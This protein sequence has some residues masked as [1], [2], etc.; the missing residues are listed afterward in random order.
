M[1]VPW[2][3]LYARRRD[4]Q[5]R[6]GRIHALPVTKRARRVIAPQVRPGMRVLDVGA[7]ARRVAEVLARD[8]GSVAYESVDPDGAG[9]HEHA[10]LDTVEGTFDVVV[11]LEVIEH[12]PPDDVQAWVSAVAERVGPGGRLFVST[13]NTYHPQEYLR[14]MTHRTPCAYDQLAGLLEASGLTVESIH[15]VYADTFWRRLLR[16]HALGW[17]FRLLSLDYARQ[18]LIS[19]VRAS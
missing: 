3:E 4:I 2:S 12:V 8:V 9:T 10:S 7:G 17:L 18:V 13:P 1:T 5:R 6:F 11:S 14:D 15:R 19:A 16:R